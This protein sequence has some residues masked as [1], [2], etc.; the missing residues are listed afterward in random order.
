MSWVIVD[1]SLNSQSRYRCTDFF[2][3]GESVVISST[4]CACV[5]SVRYVVVG[6]TDWFA[7][8]C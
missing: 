2:E 6:A 7:S 8:A 1:Q 5:S 3:T 4:L